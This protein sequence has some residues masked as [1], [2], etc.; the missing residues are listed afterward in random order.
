MKVYTAHTLSLRQFFSNAAYGS[1]ALHVL[2]VFCCV[3]FYGEVAWHSIG[4]SLILA[5][6]TLRQQGCEVDSRCYE[7]TL[8]F[9][10]RLGRAPTGMAGRLYKALFSVP[11][12]SSLLRLLSFYLLS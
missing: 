5:A 8:V 1:Y 3:V 11:C 7:S 9:G 2:Q 4:R 10:V 6:F 12:T